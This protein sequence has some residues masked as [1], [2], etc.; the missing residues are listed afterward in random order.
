[1]INNTIGN[2]TTGILQA[3]EVFDPVAGAKEEHQ[4]SISNPKTKKI[5]NLT[6]YFELER[7]TTG[8]VWG[9]TR[10]GTVRFIHPSQVLKRYIIVYIQIIAD[11]NS[12]KKTQESVRHTIGGDKAITKEK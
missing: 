8:T 10:T 11:I 6:I 7:L 3:N 9:E 4:H 1:M 5:L 12:H 2:I